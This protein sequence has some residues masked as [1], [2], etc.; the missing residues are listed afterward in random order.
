MQPCWHAPSSTRRACDRSSKADEILHQLV[1]VGR[2]GEGQIA[3]SQRKYGSRGDD[4]HFVGRYGEPWSSCSE[5][6]RRASEP[7]AGEMPVAKKPA[8]R[9]LGS[10]RDD[11]GIGEPL[12][13][14]QC[15]KLLIGLLAKDEHASPALA[16]RPER[17]NSRHWRGYEAHRSCIV[18]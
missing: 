7:V 15:P 17:L 14:L 11:K 2:P 8:L 13:K 9:K 12:N 1:L 6:Q 3:H 4:D 18:V 10:T 5:A 16:A